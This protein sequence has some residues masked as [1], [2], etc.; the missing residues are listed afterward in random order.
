MPDDGF[1]FSGKTTH[2]SETSLPN[3]QIHTRV[4]DAQ[5]RAS[6]AV[7]VARERGV[8]IDDAFRIVREGA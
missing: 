8:S 7:E 6:R 2:E 3:E 1:S 4:K 5:W